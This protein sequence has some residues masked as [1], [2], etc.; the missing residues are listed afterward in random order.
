ML[1][2]LNCKHAAPEFLVYLERG[3]MVIWTEYTGQM[4]N[5]EQCQREIKVGLGST[6][7]RVA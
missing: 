2:E 1:A 6:D 3:N 5:R 4:S 7:L